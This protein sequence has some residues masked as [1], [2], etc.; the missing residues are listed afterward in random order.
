MKFRVYIKNE[1][2]SW[3]ADYAEPDVKT[4]S[5]AEAFGRMIV[6]YFN[7]TLQPGELRREFVKAEIISSALNS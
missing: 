2:E 6:D 3:F 5:D 1:R 7:G 4:L